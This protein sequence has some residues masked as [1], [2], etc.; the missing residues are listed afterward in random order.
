MNKRNEEKEQKRNAFLQAIDSILTA[1]DVSTMKEIAERIGDSQTPT[2]FYNIKRGAS[3]PT[4]EIAQ[5]LLQHFGNNNVYDIINEHFAVSKPASLLQT[6]LPIE[7]QIELLENKLSTQ[8]KRIELLEAS[9]KKDG[10]N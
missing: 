10:T 9:I 2:L 3:T 4:D 6:E 1:F 5:K 7:K 8:D